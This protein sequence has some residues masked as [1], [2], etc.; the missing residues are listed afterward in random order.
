[1]SEPLTT[2]FLNDQNSECF[3]GVTHV[4]AF[5]NLATVRNEVFQWIG[6]STP[7]GNGVINFRWFAEAIIEP[8]LSFPQTIDS[9]MALPRPYRLCAFLP[10]FAASIRTC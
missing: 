7:V 8:T 2:I 6:F 3:S 5:V 4:G 10:I 9:L 1:M